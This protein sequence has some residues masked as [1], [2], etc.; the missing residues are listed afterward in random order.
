[1]KAFHRAGSGKIMKIIVFTAISFTTLAGILALIGPS[2]GQPN[3]ETAPIFVST[4]PPGYRDWRLISVAHEEGS[5]NSFAAVLGND[6]AIKAYR[7]GT[8][9]FPDGAIIASLH[10]SHTPSEE[11]NKV[12]G[13][14][15]SFIAGVPTNVQFM[16]KDSTTYAATGGW[17]FAHF[18]DGKPADDQFMKTCFPCHNQAKARDLVFTRYAP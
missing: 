12:F 9:P 17:G 13:R 5:F 15:Q 6:V 4:I 8:L 10:Y 2:Y 11:N 1:M 7:Q 14:S 3:T 16:V 18:K